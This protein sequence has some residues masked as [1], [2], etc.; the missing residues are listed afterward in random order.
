MCRCPDCH[1]PLSVRAWLMVADCWRCGTSIELTEEQEQEAHRLLAEQERQ[2]LR[3]T[4]AAPAR[5]AAIPAPHHRVPHSPSL[6]PAPANSPAAITRPN[7]GVSRHP[8]GGR[9]P[10]GYTNLAPASVPRHIGFPSVPRRDAG[11]AAQPAVPS[12]PA[13]AARTAQDRRDRRGAIHHGFHV[14]QSR[15]ARR[16]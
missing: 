13:H 6:K 7:A 3:E 5:G 4:T 11:M 2:T 9:R 10:S 8:L 14:G 1:A 16:W 15:R 12:P